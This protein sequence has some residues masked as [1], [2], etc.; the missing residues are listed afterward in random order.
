MLNKLSCAPNNAP[1][2][3]DSH[4]SVKIATLLTIEKTWNQPTCPLVSEWIN[5]LWYIQAMRY[6]SAL[7][8]N[9]LSSHEKTW[10]NL[11]CILLSGRNQSAKATY[12]MIPTIWHSFRVE[13]METL[14]TSVVAKGW[15]KGRKGRIR[16]SKEDF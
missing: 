1:F 11:K 2:N 15:E 16:Q 9:E 6:Y 13:T 4:K 7:K 8:R 12:Y 10:R 14:K 5:K 3:K